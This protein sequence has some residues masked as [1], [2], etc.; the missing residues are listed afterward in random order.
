MILIRSF[1]GCRYGRHNFPIRS[2]ALFLEVCWHAL[3]D[4]GQTDEHLADTD[5]GVFLGGM[6]GDHKALL[7]EAGV[8]EAQTLWGND[9]AI[10]A[11][12]IAYFLNL[13]GP[14]LALNAA[15]SS[16]LV[17][18]HLACQALRNEEASM[19]IAGGVHLATTPA[20]HVVGAN[21]GML[22]PWWALSGF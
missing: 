7:N 2:S 10:T 5:C 20:L 4:A 14:A 8:R 9:S 15:C 21:A 17:A 18:I 13:K 3:E 19:M 11:A 12:R 6:E 22:S 1:S 16:S